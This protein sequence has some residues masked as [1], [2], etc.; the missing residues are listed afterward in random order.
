MA[1]RWSPFD[2]TKLALAQAQNFGMVGSGAISLLNVDQTGITCLK[3][4]QTTDTIFD[5]C[6]NEGN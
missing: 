6:F 5:V 2:G 1:V 4:L 3:Q